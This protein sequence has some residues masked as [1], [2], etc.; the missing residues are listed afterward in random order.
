MMMAD[1]LFILRRISASICSPPT[2]TYPPIGDLAPSSA[3]DMV[4]GIGCQRAKD[5]A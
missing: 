5:H 3:E 4:G 1:E 2:G